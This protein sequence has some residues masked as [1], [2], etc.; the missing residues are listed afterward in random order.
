MASGLPTYGLRLVEAAESCDGCRFFADERSL[1]DGLGLCR[2]YPP[3]DAP[4]GE[5]RHPLVRDDDWCGEYE[6][7]LS[8]EDEEASRQVLDAG[9]VDVMRNAFVP[10]D[11]LFVAGHRRLHG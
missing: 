6:P 1:A 8:P 3:M 2:R 5:Y 10:R 4:P 9:S 11:M 7:L